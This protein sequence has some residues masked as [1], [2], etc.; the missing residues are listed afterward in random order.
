MGKKY[1]IIY[2][3][4]PWEYQNWTDK[5]NGAVKSHYK[6]LSVEDICKLPVGALAEENC[7]LFLWATFPKLKEA[8]Q[9]MEAWGFRYISCAFTWNKTYA[10][11]HPYCGLGF[12]TRSGSEICLFGLRGKAPERKSHS[13]RQIITAP[14]IKPHSSKPPIVRDKIIELFGDLPRIELFARPTVPVGWDAV[15]F[16]IDGKDIND[17]LSEI[18][19]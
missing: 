2:A 9:S 10:D 19:K 4:P 17:A 3:D 16:E 18:I 15:G 11:G 6:T 7:A 13:V 5:K 14:V 1:N 8:I 12:Y